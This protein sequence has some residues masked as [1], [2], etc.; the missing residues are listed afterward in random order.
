MSEELVEMIPLGDRQGVT[1]CPLL[2]SL[3]S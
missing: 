1:I 2:V 3:F